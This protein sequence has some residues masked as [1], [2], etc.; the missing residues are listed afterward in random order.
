[1]VFDHHGDGRHAAYAS[2]AAAFIDP[3]GLRR[4]NVGVYFG[5]SGMDYA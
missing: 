5:A 4:G 1:V 2:R 3:T